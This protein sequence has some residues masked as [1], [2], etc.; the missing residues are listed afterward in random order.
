MKKIGMLVAVEIDSVLSKYG[1]PTTTINQSG[2]NVLIYE[3]PDYTYYV[4]NS[5]IGE[6]FAAAGTQFLITHLNVDM[7][8]N[9]GLVGGTTKEMARTSLCVVEKVVHYDYDLSA[10]NKSSVGKYLEYDTI[11]I[12]TTPDLVQKALEFKPDLHKVICASGDKFVDAGEKKSALYTNY[13][14]EIC[15]MESA[16]ITLTCNKNNVPC[17]LI[18]AVSDSLMES[19]EEFNQALENISAICF[20]VADKIIKDLIKRS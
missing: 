9:F 1:K 8:L 15:D 18:K 3:N 7:I 20:D 10:W 16:A 14:A 12:P 13:K 11:Y 4:L 6:I 5:G 2:Y 19:A 17:L